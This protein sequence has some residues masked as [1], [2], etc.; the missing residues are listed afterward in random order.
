[1]IDVGGSRGLPLELEIF[2]DSDGLPSNEAI[3]DQIGFCSAG[4]KD[5]SLTFLADFG[6]VC[7][8]DIANFIIDQMYVPSS[9]PVR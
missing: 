9:R 7:G 4:C 6:S 3:Q 2:G 1:M 5:A 8:V